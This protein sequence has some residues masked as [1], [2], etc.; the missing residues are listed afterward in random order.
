M[1]QPRG[2]RIACPIVALANV[3]RVRH[4]LRMQHPVPGREISF[5]PTIGGRSSLTPKCLQVRAQWTKSYAA[6]LAERNVVNTEGFHSV[7]PLV[8]IVG[9]RA[10]SWPVGRGNSMK[11][12]AVDIAEKMGYFGN[13][14][15]ADIAVAGGAAQPNRSSW[16][17]V[18]T[19]LL[20][21]HERVLPPGT[22]WHQRLPSSC[23][24]Y[25]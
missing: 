16:R 11:A 1:R 10:A 20:L 9:R 15:Q 22:G 2:G 24:A 5:A 18:P 13:L 6:R 8:S 21:F 19:L 17:H 23:N 3:G 4:S 7:I 12:T 14:P 25:R